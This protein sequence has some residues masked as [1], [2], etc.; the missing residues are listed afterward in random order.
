M[1]KL[2]FLNFKWSKQFGNLNSSSFKMLHRV[3]VFKLI[4]GLSLQVEGIEYAN[5]L[6][7]QGIK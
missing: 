2:M 3:E 5:G 1:V 4:D 6:K 7:V